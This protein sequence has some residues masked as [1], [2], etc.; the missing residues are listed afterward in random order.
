MEI[1]IKVNSFFNNQSIL[2]FLNYYLVGKSKRKELTFWVNEEKVQLNHLLK[3]N[4]SLLI[5]Y[6]DQI[7]FEPLD[8]RLKILYEDDHLLIV[9][10]PKGMLVHPDDKTKNGTL[11][12][13]VANYYQKTNQNISVRYLHR[14]DV[15]TTGIVLFA[16][17]ILCSSYLND[18]IATHKLAREYLCIV[19][20]KFLEDKGVYNHP[21]AE[22]RH[23]ANKKRVGPTGKEAITYWKVIKRLSKNLNL[24]QVKL[25]TGRTHQI[26]VHFSYNGH[27]LLGDGLYNGNTNLLDRQALHSYRVKFIHPIT[28]KEVEVISKLPNDMEKIVERYQNKFH[29]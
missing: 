11:C 4:D 18:Q 13:V 7:D 26:R 8:V 16:K 5:S 20:G 28:F 15:D 10:K 6:A 29:S 19:S 9:D 27:P 25:A 12:N 1:K 23:V 3:E 24:L 2:D 21:I 17:D 14:I 22:D